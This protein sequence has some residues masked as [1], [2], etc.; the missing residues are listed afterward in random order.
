MASRR[1]DLIYAGAWEVAERLEK[2]YGLKAICTAGILLLDSL[3]PG[4]R[5]AAVI[6][7]RELLPEFQRKPVEES[8]LSAETG[9]VTSEAAARTRQESRR[10]PKLPDSRTGRPL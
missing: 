3:P 2:A 4:E 9:K 8:G 7:A 1:E 5:D 6:R 10:K